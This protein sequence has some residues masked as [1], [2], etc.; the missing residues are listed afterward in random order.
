MFRSYWFLFI[1]LRV[2]RIISNLCHDDW[3]STAIST[4]VQFFASPVSRV[5]YFY[6]GTSMRPHFPLFNIYFNRIKYYMG[7]SSL[8]KLI[9]IK[10][11][12]PKRFVTKSSLLSSREF[13]YLFVAF[14]FQYTFLNELPTK[15]MLTAQHLCNSFSNITLSSIKICSQLSD[16]VYPLYFR[17]ISAQIPTLYRIQCW[18]EFLMKL[19]VSIVWEEI[20]RFGR[21]TSDFGWCCYSQI[22]EHAAHSISIQQKADT[23]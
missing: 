19:L 22:A 15:K 21:F 20:L 8:S 7:M 18:I 4:F 16:T 6:I 9:S 17:R 1:V 11:F 23:I 5:E 13:F 2:I 10:W 3:S 14:S 12:F